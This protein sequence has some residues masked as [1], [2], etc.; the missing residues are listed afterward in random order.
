MALSDDIVRLIKEEIELDPMG[1][2]Y[3]DKTDEEITK[4]LNAPVLKKRIVVDTFP[5]RINQIL[6]GVAGTPNAIQSAD[7]TTANKVVL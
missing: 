1:M 2:G 4:L 5:C 7:V 6:L 3:K